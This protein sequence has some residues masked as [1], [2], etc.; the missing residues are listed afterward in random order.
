MTKYKKKCGTISQNWYQ[1][2]F[3]QLH[4]TQIK[5]MLFGVFEL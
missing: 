3:F 5:P 4:V 2:I 1:S